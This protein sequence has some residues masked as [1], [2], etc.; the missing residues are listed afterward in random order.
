MTPAQLTTQTSESFKNRFA[1]SLYQY[2]FKYKK[3]AIF[4]SSEMPPDSLVSPGSSSGRLL[5]PWIS[6]G[7]FVCSRNPGIDSFFHRQVHFHTI[8]LF[9]LLSMIIRNIYLTNVILV[10]TN[11]EEKD[12]VM[13]CGLS[14]GYAGRSRVLLVVSR[15]TGANLDPN[16]LLSESIVLGLRWVLLHHDP[17][18]FREIGAFHVQHQSSL[19]HVPAAA[20]G[21]IALKWAA[22][23]N[24]FRRQPNGTSVEVLVRGIDGLT[25]AR[26]GLLGL[27]NQYPN[28]NFMF[29]FT[30]RRKYIIFLSLLHTRTLFSCSYTFFSC[31]CTF[32]F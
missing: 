29:I 6:A 13:T 22:F 23:N 26:D 16:Q 7:S 24:F 1:A 4:S 17:N 10:A 20:V 5:A 3:S 32:F 31:S 25:T 12:A 19:R 14:W 27:I 28:L 8:F 9:I 15:E 2:E 11:V 21:A 18:S 30:Q